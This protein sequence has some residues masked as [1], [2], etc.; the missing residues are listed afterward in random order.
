[1]STLNNDYHHNTI[2]GWRYLMR[3]KPRFPLLVAYDFNTESTFKIFGN[4]FIIF[5][6]VVNPWSGD[7]WW[8]R[9]GLQSALRGEALVEFEINAVRA[10]NPQWANSPHKLHLPD[11]ASKTGRL[12][13]QIFVLSKASG[14]FIF[15]PIVL[16]VRLN[17]HPD[18][19][20]WFL[21]LFIKPRQIGPFSQLS[22]TCK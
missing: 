5:L 10:E 11:T 18:F 22:V 15:L 16:L 6:E 7:F 20:K 12:L 4:F 21:L 14:P 2:F 3:C 19:I 17:F 8:W 9:W 13:W 1:M